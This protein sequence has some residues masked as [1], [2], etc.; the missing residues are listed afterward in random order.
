MC[1]AALRKP[2]GRGQGAEAAEPSWDHTAWKD[3]LKPVKDVQWAGRSRPGS[4]KLSVRGNPE[5]WTFVRFRLPPLR[6]DF[7]LVSQPVHTE[8]TCSYNWEAWI[9]GYRSVNEINAQ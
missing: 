8:A 3:A 1:A 6:E 7:M 2:E 4:L 5:L 9:V